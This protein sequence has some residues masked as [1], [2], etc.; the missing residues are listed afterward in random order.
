MDTLN[1]HCQLLIIK[2]L[3]L[4]DQLVLFEATKDEPTNRLHVNLRNTWQQ[5]PSFYLDWFLV[6][7]ENKLHDFLTIISPTVQELII[8]R[9]TVDAM[10]RWTH[11]Q[12]PEMRSLTYS[13][14]IFEEANPVIQLMADIFPGINSIKPN[15]RFDLI[16]LTNWKNICKLELTNWFPKLPI[17]STTKAIEGLQMLEELSL[18]QENFTED[19]IKMLLRLPKLQTFAVSY[20][21]NNY[22]RCIIESMRAKD[23]WK[24]S[25][26][27]IN[28][29]VLYNLTFMKNLRKVS[30]LDTKLTITIQNLY[31]AVTSLP[32]LERLDV[33]DSQIWDLEMVLWQFV[34]ACPCLKVLNISIKDI[35][36]TFFDEDRDYM[37]TVLDKRSTPL[38]LFY[39]DIGYN[40]HMFLSHFKH[41]NLNISYRPLKSDDRNCVL[42]FHPLA[43][44]SSEAET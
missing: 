29:V 6:I 36:D 11:Y 25:F 2:Y 4:K 28:E 1:D 37:N 22:F 31:E 32:L 30:L 23:I 26:K 44:S 40:E 17:D 13:L 38:N 10:K 8:D 35:Y 12:F 3:S 39:N 16:H 14:Y 42:H 33:A 43:T 18:C 19:Q 34:A 15:G 20:P 41:P 24:V 7:P 5:E 21:H 27:S 9:V